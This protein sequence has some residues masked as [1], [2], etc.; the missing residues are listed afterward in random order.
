MISV[1]RGTFT[2][3]GSPYSRA[4]TAPWDR[5]LPV[6]MTSALTI[7]NTGV[8]P[9]SVVGANRQRDAKRFTVSPGGVVVIPRR[10][11]LK[12]SALAGSAPLP[13]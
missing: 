2:T 9:G 13:P 11:K 12:N 3:A 10:M 5:A 1:A 6:S 4:K 8:H 7:K